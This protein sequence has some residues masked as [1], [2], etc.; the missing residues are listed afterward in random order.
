LTFFNRF[1]IINNILDPPLEEGLSIGGKGMRINELYNQ[2][3]QVISLE[4]FPP[5]KE[6]SLNSLYEAMHELTSLSPD[7][8]SVTYSAGGSGNSE[9]TVQI[10]SDI[11]NKYNTESL[12]HLTCI[13]ADETSIDNYV[14][15]LMDN[16]IQ[17]ILAL[18]GD[19]PKGVD[20]SRNRFKYAKDLI[21]YIKDK[22]PSL[23]I[24]AAAYPEGHADCDNF[25]DSLEHLKEKVDG[26]A[27]FLITQL[28]FDNLYFYNFYEKALK[29][30][31]NIPIS[32]GIMPILS[33]SQIE[34]MIFMCGASLPSKIVRLLNKYENDSHSLKMAGIEYAANQIID[35]CKNG[36]DGVHIY[37]MNQPIIARECINRLKEAKN[38]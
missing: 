37:T 15:M 11:K 17:N 16:N 25:E 23:C 21:F 18:R 22:Y 26:G 35:L 13:S 8:I 5:K 9:K 2:K 3:R 34:K 30:G 24:G 7:F 20:I 27:D 19:I 14:K 6:D 32:A 12:A 36:V 33:R 29:K 28:F 4:I 38:G 1:V 10:A 31:I